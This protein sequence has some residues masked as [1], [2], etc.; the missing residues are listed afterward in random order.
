V[1]VPVHE[2]FLMQVFKKRNDELFSCAVGAE[3]GADTDKNFK[4]ADL[5]VFGSHC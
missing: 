5:V 3:I 2:Q 4:M 1:A